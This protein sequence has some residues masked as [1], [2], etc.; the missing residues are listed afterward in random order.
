MLAFDAVAD[1]TPEILCQ[2]RRVAPRL[3]H[4]SSRSIIPQHRCSRSSFEHTSAV[5]RSDG[6]SP[7]HAPRGSHS[8]ANRRPRP[9]W[10]MR[11]L[12]G[13][14]RHDSADLGRE[15]WRGREHQHA[16]CEETAVAEIIVGGNPT[17]RQ[18]RRLRA[19]L[20][21]AGGIAPAVPR[22]AAGVLLVAR[23]GRPK[24]RLFPVSNRSSAGQLRDV[25]ISSPHGIICR[26]RPLSVCSNLPFILVCC[27]CC[28]SFNPG[29]FEAGCPAG[30]LPA[31]LRQCR[32]LGPVKE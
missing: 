8:V 17:P 20:H 4:R 14:G 7:S 16:E 11:W 30:L 29:A 9:V 32:T 15:E 18:H 12:D 25:R 24:L 23:R 31:A 21:V 6:M 5:K 27:I 19:A 28:R 2:L 26:C 22:G 13:G 1:Q 3:S 10:C